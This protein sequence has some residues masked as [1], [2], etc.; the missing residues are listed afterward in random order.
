MTE[1]SSAERAR[2][3]RKV[4]LIA[5]VFFLPVAGSFALYYGGF[6]R[7]GDSSARGELIQPTRTLEITGLRNADG[8][9]AGDQPLKDKWSIVYIGDGGCDE[10]CKT[11]LTY[12]RQSWIAL[13]KDADRVRRVF[14]SIANCCN[15]S[16]LGIE[17]P[18]IVA[19][20]AS[21]PEAAKLLQ[22][23]PG[24]HAKSLYVVDPLGNLVLRHDADHV[25]N[26]ALLTD[27]KKLLKL[28]HIG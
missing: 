26:K 23:F 12:G 10:A 4:L 7:P 9:P 24:E 22:Q 3:R 14:L 17:Q 20:D 25:V 11:A 27:L 19:I 2:G 5:A 16:W 21:S 6:W 1:F 28:S 8:S 15:D 18:G 13:G